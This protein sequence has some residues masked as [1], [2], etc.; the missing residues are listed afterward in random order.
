MKK[1]LFLFAI[2]FF[3]LSS[4][5]KEEVVEETVQLTTLEIT[6]LKFL[7]EE[8]KLARDVYMYASSV[9]SHQIF[10]N[11]PLSEQKHMDQVLVLLEK[12]GIEDPA[13]SDEGVFNNTDL[14][15]LYDEL[16]DKVDVSLIDAL[17][18]GA[19][20]EDLD[21]FDI[22]RI[23]IRTDKED[24]LSMYAKLKCGSRNH[25]RAYIGQLDSR[26]ETYS[27]QYLTQKEIDEILED[28]QEDC[29]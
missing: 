11:I 4:G 20:I 10:V 27:A 28:G 25:L 23:E 22:A 24:I 21:I 7:R 12:Y 8:E 16:T 18:V 13:L 5:C 17:E 1:L 9:H 6:D 26:G 19:T 14:Q 29:N 15:Q 3:F 2:S